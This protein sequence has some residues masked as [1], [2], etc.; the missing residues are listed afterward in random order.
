MMTHDLRFYVLTLPN[1][2]WSESLARY[3]YIEDLGFDVAATADHFVDWTNPPSPW[4]EGWTL[5]AAVARE[6]T[7]IRLTTCVTQIPLRNP[8]LLARQALTV[9]HISNGRLEVGLG[10]GLTTDPSYDMMG[11]PNWTAKERVARFKEYVEIVDKLLSNEVTTYKGKFYEV[12]EA[13]M[14]PRPVQQPRPPLLIAAMGPIMLKRA[15]RYADIWN[16]LSFADTFETQLEE[17]RDRIKLVDEHCTAIGRDPS[18]LRRSYQMFDAGARKS[19]GLFNYYESEQVF[20]DMVRRLTGLG[21][22]EF[23]LYYPMRD[24][25]LPMF[26]RIA[27]EVIPELRAAHGARVRT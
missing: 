27:R 21:I 5:L 19:G 14:N 22:S 11:I 7:H 12:K 23:G 1:V 17:T 15:A 25:Q 13:V 18:S 24:E 20:I 10:I 9:D 4:L 16:S 6:T 26:E 2:S 8:A 3:K